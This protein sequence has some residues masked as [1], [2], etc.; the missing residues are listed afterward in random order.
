MSDQYHVAIIG[1]GPGP[2]DDTA[3]GYATTDPSPSSMGFTHARM[4]ENIDNCELI[5]CVDLIEEHT[6]RFA[7][8]FGLDAERTYTDYEEMLRDADPD[9]VSICT[10]TPTHSEIVVDCA[11]IGD[12]QAIHCEKPMAHT[13]LACRNMVQECFRRNIQLTIAH[14]QRM[15]DSAQRAK[16][17]IDNGAIGDLQR[18]EIN[19]MNFF[20]AGMHQVDLCNYFTGDHPAKWMLA[21]L[22]YHKKYIKKGVPQENPAVALWEYDDG[23]HGFATIGIEDFLDTTLRLVGTD[24]VIERDNNAEEI[25]LYDRSGGCEVINC[26][27]GE[28]LDA[29]GGIHP[30]TASKIRHVVEALERGTEPEVNARDALNA[31]EIV[32]GARESSR[33]RARIDLPLQI[34][35]DPLS[36]M[37]E[38]G[39]IRPEKQ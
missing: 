16:K 7:E 34:D 17:L 2:E 20:D 13:W 12:L 15:S 22:G 11:V 6:K 26:T 21:G 4:Y 8:T 38:A 23:V 9:I 1:T 35:D 39:E 30:G 36:S 3:H 25:R 33:Q 14:H 31:A 27:E 29:A 28:F 37:I 24:G 19:R 10:P 32:F 5:A 18:I